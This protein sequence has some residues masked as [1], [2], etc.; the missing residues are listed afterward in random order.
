MDAQVDLSFCWV[1][2]SDNTFF[3]FLFIYLFIYF[4]CFVLFCFCLFYIFFH[5]AAQMNLH[6]LK[7]GA[8]ITRI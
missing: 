8:V 2:M 1:H 5:V 7:T 6:S 4:L 3:L